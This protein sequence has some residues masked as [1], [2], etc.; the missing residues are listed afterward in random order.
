M[1]ADLEDENTTEEIELIDY[2]TAGCE[3]INPHP[4]QVNYKK[5]IQPLNGET[6]EQRATFYFDNSQN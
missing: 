3:V 6:I 1:A 2:R 5:T 4:V